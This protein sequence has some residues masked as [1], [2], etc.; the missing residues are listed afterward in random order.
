MARKVSSN[1][2]EDTIIC[3]LLQ[4]KLIHHQQNHECFYH[5][6]FYEANVDESKTSSK[7]LMYEE[8]GH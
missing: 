1:F 5:M 2:S 7:T 6:T 8:G 4:M 3:A